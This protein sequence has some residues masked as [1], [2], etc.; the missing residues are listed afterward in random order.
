MSDPLTALMHAVQ[1]MNLLMTLIMKTL[2]ER[3]EAEGSQSSFHSSEDEYDSEEEMDT[4][5]GEEE[6]E[7]DNETSLSEIEDEEG[8]GEAQ[9]SLCEIEECAMSYTESE[10]RK[11]SSISSSSCEEKSMRSSVDSISPS[12]KYEGANSVEIITNLTDSLPVATVCIK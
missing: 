5:D 10:A 8:E 9:P 1:V 11:C 3:E 6:E 4:S 7:E 12:L 2:A